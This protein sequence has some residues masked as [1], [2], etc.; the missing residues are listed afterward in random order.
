MGSAKYTLLY[1]GIL[2]V[3]IPIVSS[4]N[5]VNDPTDCPV[6][7]NSVSCTG[8]E[9]QCGIDSGSG[10]PYCYDM[11]SISPPGS[12]ET[13]TSNNIG[14]FDGGFL[15]NCEDT[16]QGSEPYCFPSSNDCDRASLCYDTRKR[17][18]TCT[19]DQWNDYSCGSCRSGYNDCDADGLVCEIQNGAS[20]GTNG[21]YSGCDGSS[22]DCECKNNY[23]DCDASGAG[24]GDGCEILDG[25]SCS[26]GALSGTYDCS[27]GAGACYNDEGGTEYDC[28]CVVDTSY[29]ETGVEVEYSTSASQSFLWGTDYG[30]GNLLELNNTNYGIFAINSSGCIIW[31]DGTSTCT[32]PTGGGDNSSWNESYANTLYQSLEDQGLSTTDAVTFSTVD[33]GQ[34]S[35]ELYDMD[36]NVLTTSNVIF[37]RMNLTGDLLR[38]DNAD[39]PTIA[40]IDTTNTVSTVMQS[41]N[42]VG[43][44]GTS[45]NHPFNILVNSVTSAIFD[46]GQNVTFLNNVSAGYYFG[47]GSQLTNL[48]ASPMDY[49]NLAFTNET[50]DFEAE[51]NFSQPIRATNISSQGGGSYFW[52]N[53][54]DFIICGGC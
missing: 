9:L 37:N 3:L 14:G 23:Y 53:E 1:L 43:L 26:V 7:Y 40:V 33:T 39:S 6:E 36:Q 28:T 13:T 49:T 27:V 16:S 31:V 44:F 46:T 2:I 41:G 30:S 24:S 51:Q 18:T 25:G 19:A 17:Q 48:P 32:N 21:Q 10:G 12:S 5:W 52:M 8:G 42:T 35:N 50:N 29:F 4:A 54:T 45:T 20:C 11:S 34:G 22:G 38:V 47:D 15:L